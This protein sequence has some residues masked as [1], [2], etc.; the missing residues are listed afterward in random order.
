MQDLVKISLRTIIRRN[1]IW[2][3]LILVDKRRS[4]YAERVS[5]GK[6]RRVLKDETIAIIGYGVQGPGQSLN[7]KDNGFKVIIGQSKQFMQDWNRAVKD[8]WKPGVNLFEIN[9][10]VKRGTVIEMLVSDAAQ[11]LIWPEV[12]R[13]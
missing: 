13:T 10:A 4:C 8:G 1:L 3:S 6:A 2:Q 7:L 11:R 5:Y 9:E 12:K